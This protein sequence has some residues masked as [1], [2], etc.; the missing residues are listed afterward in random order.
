MMPLNQSFDFDNFRVFLQQISQDSQQNNYDSPKKA[1][2]K[3]N[4]ADKKPKTQSRIS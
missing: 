2:T 1:S 3:L 4:Y